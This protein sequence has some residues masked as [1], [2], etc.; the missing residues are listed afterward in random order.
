MLS[1]QVAQ[2]LDNDFDNAVFAYVPN[3][4]ATAFYGLI[5][6]VHDIIRE[7][8]AE[9]IGKIDPFKDTQRLREILDWKPRRQKVLIKDAK[10]RTFIT[11]DNEREGVV[12][13][14]YDVTYGTIRPGQDSLVIIDDSIARNHLAHKHFKNIGQTGSQKDFVVEFGTANPLPRLLRH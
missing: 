4:A 1:K 9:A 2:R 10:M 11:N 13:G 3:T 5:D 7:K 8:Q 12:G 6:G 14:A